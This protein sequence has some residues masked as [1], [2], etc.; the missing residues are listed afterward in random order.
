MKTQ[1]R[2]FGIILGTELQAELIAARGDEPWVTVA[3][4]LEESLGDF[5]LTDPKNFGVTLLI[6]GVDFSFLLPEQ[7]NGEF[8]TI[9]SLIGIFERKLE[10]FDE[11]SYEMQDRYGRFVPRIGRL[12]KQLYDQADE[13]G[14]MAA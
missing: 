4:L 8:A 7:S 13:H 3:R 11:L 5:D 10:G 9:S 1:H 14:S 12:M 2:T 6:D